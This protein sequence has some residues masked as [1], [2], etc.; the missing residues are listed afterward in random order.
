ME[1]NIMEEITGLGI[2]LL[3]LLGLIGIL[4]LIGTRVKKKFTAGKR[5]GWLIAHILMVITY[6]SGMLMTLL[7]NLLATSNFCSTNEQIYTAHLFAKYADW[8]MVIPGALGCLITGV[9]LAIR[10]QGGLTKQRWVLVKVVTAI[11]AVLYGASL[12]KFSYSETVYLSK[13]FVDTLNYDP[14]YLQSRS[15]MLINTYISLAIMLFMLI[16]S[17]MR[18]WRKK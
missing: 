3:V 7:L 8:F 2:M 17:Y 15:L 16:V 5:K 14:A 6:F 10:A 1:F 18:P 12:V 9:W 13:L 11:L 4:L